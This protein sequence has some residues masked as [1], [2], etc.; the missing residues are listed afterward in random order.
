MEK[1]NEQVEQRKLQEFHQSTKRTKKHIGIKRNLNMV[2]YKHPPL[3][4]EYNPL[5]VKIKNANYNLHF[6]SDGI[7]KKTHN[8]TAAGGGGAL[9]V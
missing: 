1:L 8:V 9:Q 6:N 5:N 7:S 2:C 4:K 3:P